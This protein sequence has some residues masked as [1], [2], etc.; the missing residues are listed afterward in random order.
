MFFSSPRANLYL[1]KNV[2]KLGCQVSIQILFYFISLGE[3]S[4]KQ[5]FTLKLGWIYCCNSEISHPVAIWGALQAWWH[6]EGVLQGKR[7]SFSKVS[8]ATFL[9]TRQSCLL[10]WRHLCSPISS[11]NFTPLCHIISI[12]ILACSSLAH[13]LAGILNR[14]CK[15]ESNWIRKCPSETFTEADKLSNLDSSLGAG[16]FPSLKNYSSVRFTVFCISIYKKTI[17]KGDLLWRDFT[18]T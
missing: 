5:R 14:N 16:L 4:L 8:D 2:S 10:S 7:A 12:I 13:R 9:A 11:R 15:E 18:L 6:W 3:P 1:I 17:M